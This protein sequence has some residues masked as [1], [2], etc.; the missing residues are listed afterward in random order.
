MAMEITTIADSISALSVSGVKICD[1]DEIPDAVDFRQPTI[2]PLAYNF[3][4]DLAL[5]R[6]SYGGGSTAKMTIEYNLNYRLC[7]APVEEGRGLFGVYKNM[8]TAAYRFLDAV[9]AID[10][11]EG[12]EDIYPADTV[13]FGYVQDMAGNPFHGCD[14]VIHIL[15]FIN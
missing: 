12:L 8:V 7:F 1:L 11:L 13:A 3:V 5:T 14:F 2:F 4:T 9:I 15:E 6:D 10:T